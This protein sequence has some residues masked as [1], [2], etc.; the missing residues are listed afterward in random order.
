MA[1]EAIVTD[2]LGNNGDVVMYSV[3]NASAIAKGAVCILQDLRTVVTHAAVDTPVVGIAL[4]EKVA[5]DGMTQ[6]GVITNCIAK[7][8]VVGGGTTTIGD[9]V[10]MGGTANMV[11]LGA[12]LDDEKGWTIGYAL[13]DGAAGETVLVRV[14]K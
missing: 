6:I 12:T 4:H 3:A 2:L 9:T 13:E 14:Q 11:D 5:N 8:T 7:F 1:N 10:S